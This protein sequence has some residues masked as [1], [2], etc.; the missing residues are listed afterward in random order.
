MRRSQ[1][2][3]WGIAALAGLNVLL[4]LIF[5]PESDGRERFVPQMV[6]EIFSSTGMVLMACAMVLALRLRV[7]E[8]FFGGLDKMYQAHK[9]SALAGFVLV[10]LHFLTIPISGESPVGQ[11]LGRL[12]LFGFLVLIVLTL[13]PRIPWIGSPLQLAYH[14]WR[15]TH[16]LIGVFFILGLVHT[17][18]VK[19]VLQFAEIPAMYWKIAAYGG[20]IA[21]GYRILLAP[22][23]SRR[24]AFV[25]EAAN[26]LNP[27]TIEV[28]LRP[29]GAKP[30]QKAGQ[31]LFV[32]FPSD[33][34]LA[35]PHP[36]TISSAPHEP[37]LRLSIK[38]AGDWTK[39]LYAQL[40]PGMPA[41]VDGCYGMFDYTSGGSRQIW[42]AGGIGIT[43]FLSWVRSLTSNPSQQI[44]LF[45]T[46][47]SEHDALFWDEFVQAANRFPNI[48]AVL[49]V[50][51]RDG[52]LNVER[53]ASAIGVGLSDY[54]FYMCGPAAMTK[55]LTEQLQAR[56]IAR[57]QIH[58]EEFNFR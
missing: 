38:A 5:P 19:N 14:H 47:R 2:G 26:R 44:A 41:Q 57:S 11:A 4:W 50:S 58:Y 7:L 30:P 8:P 45:Y 52:S 32:R 42:V 18:N 46:V 55:A 17:F 22:L 53:I 36:F 40:Q 27:S 16:K 31:F 37:Y 23:L 25:V 54:H 39:R 12:A 6:S 24:G 51:A 35:E 29:D 20:A 49:N 33:P 56:G 21:Y 43:P 3:I 48:Q 9:V 13:A 34:L 1:A 15:W 10:L 28:T